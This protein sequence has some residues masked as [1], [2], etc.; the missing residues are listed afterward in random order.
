M[1]ELKRWSRF[2]EK[3]GAVGDPDPVYGLLSDLYSERHRAYHTLDHV[4]HCLDEL[5]DARHLADHPNDVEMALWFH[6]AIYD[7]KAK[8]S[9]QRSAEL[10]R[11]TATEAGLPEG[12]GQRVT[13]LI[14][15]TQHHGRR[16]APMRACWWTSTYRSSVKRGT[17]STHTKPTSARSIASCRGPSIDRR[18]ARSFGVS[19]TGRPYIRRISSKPDTRAKPG[20]TWRGLWAISRTPGPEINP[21]ARALRPGCGGRAAPGW[22]VRSRARSAR[23]QR[24][25][26]APG[27]PRRPRD[28]S[29]DSGN[30]TGRG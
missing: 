28:S 15:A 24:R 26:A 20:R 1:S 5:E 8:D 11:R 18:G 14:L 19:W 6:D 30:G 9:E 3:L 2:W 13:D 21:P 22:P 10:C 23:R 17:G 27:S 12:F 29:G 25:A 4:S 7:P 16:R